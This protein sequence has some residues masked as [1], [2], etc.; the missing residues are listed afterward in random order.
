MIPAIEGIRACS[1]AMICVETFRSEVARLKV[2]AAAPVIND[3]SSL[4]GRD[5]GATVAGSCERPTRVRCTGMN[6]NGT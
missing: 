1:E 2:T 5:R 3:I 4:L 6:K